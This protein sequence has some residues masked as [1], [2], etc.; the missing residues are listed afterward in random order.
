MEARSHAMT[1]LMQDKRALHE[2]YQRTDTSQRST[3]LKVR[4]A[5]L[6]CTVE[7]IRSGFPGTPARNALLDQMCAYDVHTQEVLSVFE[8]DDFLS[9]VVT[10]KAKGPKRIQ[11]QESDDES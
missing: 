11:T 1:S 5:V 10:R 4:G 9:Y 6:K 7:D 3:L 2:Y 8:A